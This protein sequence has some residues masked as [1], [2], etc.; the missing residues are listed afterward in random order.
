MFQADSTGEE[1]FPIAKHHDG[2]LTHFVVTTEYEGGAYYVSLYM[3]G[4]FIQKKDGVIR[5]Q[6]LFLTLKLSTWQTRLFRL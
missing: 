4:H 5:V 3:N 2:S 1:S 6:V